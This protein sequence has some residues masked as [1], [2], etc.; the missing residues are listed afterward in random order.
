MRFKFHTI[1]CP[2]DLTAL[3]GFPFPSGSN[4]AA[5]DL[6]GY[7]M[8]ELTGSYFRQSSRRERFRVPQNS[9]A[10][11]D[12][13]RPRHHRDS[14]RT[15]F[16]VTLVLVLIV[17]PGCG[18]GGFNANNVT[19]TV[20]PEAVAVPANAPVTLQA[21]VHGLCSTCTPSINVWNIT[22]NN[23]VNCSWINTPPTG[24]C[25]GGTIEETG[26]NFLTVT[27]HAPSASGTFHVIAEWC[28]CLA[29]PKISK[30]GTAVITVP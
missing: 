15:L 25:P 20:A 2:G 24:P 9:T 23:G 6:G 3:P 16:L 22:E 17:T 28:D 19:V 14:G 4:V 8:I 29:N 18:G 7:T 1:D 10:S 30:D 13:R 27:Y 12:N 26:G 21:T 5:C 11:T